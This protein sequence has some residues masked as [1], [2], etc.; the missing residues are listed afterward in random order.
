MPKE[1]L[2]K[3]LPVF[4]E[5]PTT[6][7]VKELFVALTKAISGIRAPLEAK[8]DAKLAAVRD[9]VDGIN[10]KDGRDGV[11]GKDG[12]DGADG[13]S[14][15]GP[16][17][18]RGERGERGFDGLRG[19]PD[20]PTDVRDKLERLEGNERLDISAI[21]GT[22]EVLT[23][24]KTLKLRPTGGFFGG[25]K[26]IGLY[27]D[28]SKRLTTAQQ[29]NFVAGAGIT[30]SYAFAHGRN[31][32]TFTATGT[33][34][35]TPIEVTGTIDDTNTSFT[36]ASPCNQVVINGASLR[37]GHGVTITGGVNITTNSPVGSGGDIYA[38]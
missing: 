24:I 23:D 3:L 15:I 25:A 27:T 2:D 28:G 6:K 1:V 19:S 30:I 7:Q 18:E 21:R 29:L 16:R 8:I 17:G 31:D 34:S 32:I 4:S 33:A 9:G 14:I 5:Y 37:D 20:T 36:A 22:D 10:G 26:G 35:S 12:K 11:D 38:L 13:K